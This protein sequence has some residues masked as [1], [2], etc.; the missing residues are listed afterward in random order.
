[1]NIV[2][3]SVSTEHNTLKI[4]QSH[5]RIYLNW[6]LETHLFLCVFV[7]NFNF[8]QIYYIFISA[9]RKYCRAKCICT[10]E[11]KSL[12]VTVLCYIFNNVYCCMTQI[13]IT[14]REQK[15]HFEKWKKKKKIYNQ[16]EVVAIHVIYIRRMEFISLLKIS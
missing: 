11:W 5:V 13:E 6:M 2:H 3:C 15:N 8:K 14:I 4:A 7:F 9:K 16:K 1:M 10:I 12:S